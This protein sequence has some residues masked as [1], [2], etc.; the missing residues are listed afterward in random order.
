[1]KIDK[2]KVTSIL[3]GL[4]KIQNRPVDKD[5]LLDVVTFNDLSEIKKAVKKLKNL[6]VTKT[7]LSQNGFIVAGMILKI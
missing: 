7:W 3:E 2:K 1:M 4:A 6:K 5:N